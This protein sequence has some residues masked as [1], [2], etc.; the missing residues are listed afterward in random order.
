MN[1]FP[2]LAVW[3]C[4]SMDG[5]AQCVITMTIGVRWILRLSADNWVTIM[6]S[7]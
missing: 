7:K 1:I 4:V 3:K 6:V 2:V 5:G